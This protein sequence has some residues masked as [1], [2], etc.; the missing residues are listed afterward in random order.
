MIVSL[1]AESDNQH[2]ASQV[3]LALYVLSQLAGSA[4]HKGVAAAARAQYDVL[5]DVW[6]EVR[7][8][9]ELPG[10]SYVAICNGISAAIT[11]YDLSPTSTAK[12]GRDQLLKL[13]GQS[14][15][16]TDPKPGGGFPWGTMFVLGLVAGGGY[17]LYRR[18]SK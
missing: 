14:L 13:V 4:K 11:L 18:R 9:P 10:W 8:K 16:V 5:F 12:E 3:E 6:T 17:Y 1:G 7:G 15:S 2:T